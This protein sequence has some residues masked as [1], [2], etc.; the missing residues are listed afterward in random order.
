MKNRMNCTRTKWRMDE[1]IPFVIY[2]GTKLLAQQGIESIM[3][4]EQQQRPLPSLLSSSFFYGMGLSF[5]KLIKR[6]VHFRTV[7][8]WV[9]FIVG[10]MQVQTGEHEDIIVMFKAVI[11]QY[12]KCCLLTINWCLMMF[13]VKCLAVLYFRKI[14]IYG[15][16]NCGRNNRKK[17]LLIGIQIKFPRMT[18][19]K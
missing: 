18:P 5:G 14:V 16:G 10:Y 4:P 7:G 19:S 15:K 11:L 8:F 2:P 13:I 12:E 9:M 3:Y 1:L 6:V 17:K